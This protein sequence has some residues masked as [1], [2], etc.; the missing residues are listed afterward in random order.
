MNLTRE[1]IM[2]ALTIGQLNKTLGE[3]FYPYV[4][5]CEGS[6][7]TA[8][9]PTRKRAGLLEDRL[10][11]SVKSVRLHRDGGFTLATEHGYIRFWRAYTGPQ[12]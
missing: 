2:Q 7:P 9:S 6:T 5:C 4:S 3:H 10:R 12:S 8:G 1:Q 11:Q